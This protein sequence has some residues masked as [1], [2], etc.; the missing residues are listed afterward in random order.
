MIVIYHNPACETSRNVLAF[1]RAVTEPVVIPYLEA[2]WTQAHLIGLFA[3]AN[4]TPRQALRTAGTPAVALGLVDPDVPDAAILDA[5][6]AHPILVNRPF[7]CSPL[8][9]RL[10]RPSETVLAL[11]PTPSG[12]LHKEDGTPVTPPR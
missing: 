4:V 2:G 11:L 6:V 3:A 1:V 12:H 7:V 10:C 8:G 9:T 5:M